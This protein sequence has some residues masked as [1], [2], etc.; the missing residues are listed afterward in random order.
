MIEKI[1]SVDSFARAGEAAASTKLEI[2]AG[3][4]G[5]YQSVAASRAGSQIYQAGKIGPDGQLLLDILTE[6]GVNTDFIRRD[7]TC[8]GHAVIQVNKYEKTCALSYGGAN[9]E[10]TRVEIDQVL[11]SFSPGDILML[12]NGISNISYIVNKAFD[13][14]IKVVLNAPPAGCVP[15]GTDL[16][17]ISYLIINESEGSALTGE[18]RP[19]KILDYL[20]S[21]YPHIKVVLTLG[22]V[23]S[24]YGDEMNRIQQSAYEEDAVDTAGAGDTFLGY[25]ISRVSMGSPPW[26][27]M[28]AAA[29]AAALSVR[30]KGVLASIPTWVEVTRFYTAKEKAVI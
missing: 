6:N 21:R 15:D 13:K 11:S 24:I 18:S 12:Q 22:K 27:A 26:A 7:G 29:Q 4:K 3:G 9:M 5:L 28:R 25:F 2:S 19:G 8:S 20:L 14:Y 10:I 30:K 23:G 1:Y 16:N 17:K